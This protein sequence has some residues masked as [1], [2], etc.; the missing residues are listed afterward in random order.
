MPSDQPTR[1][2]IDQDERLGWS[3]DRPRRAGG[4]PRKPDVSARCHVLS[5][6]DRLRYSPGS[7]VLV[8]SAS[9][10]ERER[11]ADRLV[12]EKGSVLSLEKVRDLIAG[13]VPEEQLE[14][15]ASELLDAAVAKRLG[16]NQTVVVL[17]EGLDE[18]ER[19]RFVRAAHAEGRPRH[20]ILLEG[21]APEDE[22]RRNALGRLRKSLEAGALGE[23]GFNTAL[24]LGGRTIA[25]VK[26]IV[27][28]PPPRPDDD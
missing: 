24:R 23:E 25:E 13:R 2:K 16:A 12:P 17:A 19:E 4:P 21:E 6:S 1:V 9:A 15:K 5:P 26:R 11:F 28:R 20:L 14:E 22:D 8:A 3:S 18:T 7:L 10:D 27:F